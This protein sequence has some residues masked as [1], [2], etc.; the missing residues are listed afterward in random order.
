MES[1]YSLRAMAIQVLLQS[2]L[3]T[4]PG[5]DTAAA[6]AGVGREQEIMKGGRVGYAE[7]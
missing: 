4:G 2:S 3:L 7:T 6:G 1:P 5:V